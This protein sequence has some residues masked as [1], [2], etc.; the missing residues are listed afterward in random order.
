[1]GIVFKQSALNTA[2]TFL[3]FAVG[4][5]NTLFLYTSILDDTNYGLVMVILS[6]GAILTPLMAM[7]MHN[8]LLR[9]YE[10]YR[11]PVER[12]RFLSVSLLLPLVPSGIL[13]LALWMSPGV[14]SGWMGSQN[15]RVGDYLWYIFLIGLAMAYFEV[16]YAYS[17]IHLKSVWGNALKEVFARAGAL[18][19]LGLYQWEVL[20]LDQF[21][22]GLVA[23]YLL[24]TLLMKI[25]AY[26]LHFPQFTLVRPANFRGVL[27][28][29]ALILLGGSAA[30]ILLEID[31]FMLNQYLELSN[32]AYYGVG[33]YIATIIIVPARAMHQITFPLT[34]KALHENDRSQLER[35]FK[36]TS[37][38]LLIAS[39]LLFLL[40]ITNLDDLYTLLPENYSLG[41]SIVFIIGSVKVMDASLGNINSILFYSKYYK[42]MLFL[43]VFLALLTIVLNLFFIPRWGVIGAA[44]ASFCAVVLYN[45]AK[46]IF[47]WTTF[48]L[49][50][51]T[52]RTLKL[53]LFI[54][55]FGLL[56]FYL[57][58]PF[59]GFSAI[60]FRSTLLAFLYLPGLIAL[61]FSD[62]LN[63]VFGK[64]LGK[65]K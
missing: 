44:W 52:R 24:R 59:E 64:F 10:G 11:S 23:V 58:I 16:F 61:R 37:I 46:L 14:F 43:G 51:W 3:G 38:N 9:F 5:I 4:A 15:E 55:G 50:P 20:N 1:M 26:R 31:K 12:D 45:L 25:Y 53:F 17:K 57:P 60:V 33:V 19:L 40:V 8:T 54:T 28:Y 65:S 56:F 21:F 42:G 34:A 13:A 7:G 41:W 2:I 63:Q 30:V 36:K 6:T 48:R 29:S 49:F 32:V 62:D 47:V 35:L 27:N 39:G 22:Y 18:I